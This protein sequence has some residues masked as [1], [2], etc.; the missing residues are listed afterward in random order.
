MIFLGTSSLYSLVVT[1]NHMHL[2]HA[3]ARPKRASAQ[4]CYPHAWKVPEPCPC[5]V[6]FGISTS[7]LNSHEFVQFSMCSSFNLDF[8]DAVGQNY[9]E[10]QTGRGRLIL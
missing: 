4:R 8:G 10:W 3:F 9:P 5:A 6:D 1:R 7:G 2:K